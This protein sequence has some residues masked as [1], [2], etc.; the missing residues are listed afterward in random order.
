MR[1]IRTAVYLLTFTALFVHF[2]PAIPAANASYNLQD[3]EREKLIRTW[4]GT[5]CEAPQI[6]DAGYKCADWVQYGALKQGE[7]K[8]VEIQLEGGKQYV[9]S[10]FCDKACTDF[11]L[12]L[13]DDARNQVTKDTSNDDSPVL[14][15][16][17]ANPAKFQLDVDMANC[18]DAP[19]RYGVKILSK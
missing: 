19:C 4:V 5:L 10:G 2:Y 6:K 14:Q 15:F 11:N 13:Y 8:T 18:S 3:E 9:I 1:A 12:T 7:T 16:K 17:L